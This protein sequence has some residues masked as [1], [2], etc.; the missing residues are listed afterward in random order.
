MKLFNLGKKGNTDKA[1]EPKGKKAKKKGFGKKK[2]MTLIAQ[3]GLQESVADA[4]VDVLSDLVQAGDSAVRETDDGFLIIAITNDMLEEAGLSNSSEEFGAFAEALSSETVESIALIDDL[5][6]GIIGIIPSSDTLLALDEFEFV[7]EL[8]FRWAVVPFDLSDNDRITLLDDTVGIAQLV[9]MANDA[10]VTPVVSSEG[11]SFDEVASSAAPFIHADPSSAPE[12]GD[13]DDEFD[14]EDEPDYP[15]SPST[16]ESFD[17][18]FEDEGMPDEDDVTYTP[19]VDNFDDLDDEDFDGFDDE[20][21][22]GFDT[23]DDLD[24]GGAGAV[25]TAP[26]V[27]EPELDAEEVAEAVTRATELGF[28]NDELGLGIDLKPFDQYFDSLPI[29]RFDTK[30]VDDSELHRVVANLRRDANSEIERFHQDNIQSLRNQYMT[31]MRDINSRI[32]ETIDY[33]NASTMYG[34]MWEAIQ[35]E[36]DNAVRDIDRL[37]AAQIKEIKAQYDEERELFGE[38]AKREAFVLYDARHKTERDRKID[39]VRDALLTDFKTTRDVK[40]AELYDDRRIVAKRLFDKAGTA[41]LQKLQESYETMSEKELHMYDSFRRNLDAYMRRHF[42]DDVLSKKAEAEKLR[43]SHE[44]ESVRQEF[45]QILAART[46]Q[47]NEADKQARERIFQLEERHREQL[48]A[49]T[50]QIERQL[51]RARTDADNLREQLKESQNAIVLVGQ[52]KDKE[53]EHRLRMFEDRAKAAEA[54]LEHAQK[55][56]NTNKRP[57]NFIIGAVAVVG[58]ALGIIVGFLYA[59]NSVQQVAPAAPTATTSSVDVM[60]VPTSFSTSHPTLAS[61]AG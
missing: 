30:Q 43:Q 33:K 61:I 19:P 34:E 54:Q 28:A 14:D 11:V 40:L 15:A 57:M 42:A 23:G 50:E 7:Q 20:D 60:D 45:E 46:H 25:Y 35:T 56:N 6:A 8:E 13:F 26:T 32:I 5:E 29:A 44:A 48:A 21:G 18:E 1:S 4:A 39:A 47:L 9:G 41:L 38:N 36:H 2:G 49:A 24:L 59:V 3:M 58:I 51:E 17:D 12:T 31:S 55:T 16:T 37:S 10:S 27:D 53:V 22:A 52:Q